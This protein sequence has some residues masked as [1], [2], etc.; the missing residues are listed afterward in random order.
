MIESAVDAAFV[1]ARLNVSLRNAHV[2]SSPQPRATSAVRS[3]SPL[4]CTPLVQ[5]NAVSRHGVVRVCSVNEYE[6]EL[7]P[8]H[9]AEAVVVPGA[10]ISVTD[11]GSD[12]PLR[13]NPKSA[14]RAGGLTCLTSVSEESFALVKVHVHT[15]PGATT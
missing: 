2:T 3:A 1:M 4:P 13:S 12:G 8:V 11:E 15:S 9:A 14:C 5:L 6:P 10:T 7:S